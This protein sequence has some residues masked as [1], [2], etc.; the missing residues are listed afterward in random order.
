MCTEAIAHDTWCDATGFGFVN[1]MAYFTR[2][3]YGLAK[4]TVVEATT[5]H[6]EVCKAGDSNPQWCPICAGGRGMVGN[7]AIADRSPEPSSSLV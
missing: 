2:L 7:V 6:C 1:K 5:I 4:G 3:T